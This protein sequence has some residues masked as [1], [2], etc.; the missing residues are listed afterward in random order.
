MPSNDAADT[1]R[2]AADELKPLVDPLLDI[3]GGSPDWW[4]GC[5]TATLV[6]AAGA[7]LETAAAVAS[8]SRSVTQ[9]EAAIAFVTARVFRPRDKLDAIRA[10]NADQWTD[11]LVC[12][13]PGMAQTW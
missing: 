13:I 9:D 12:S 4:R 1:A 6:E 3:R 5:D 10:N 7:L 8:G 2:R 11:W